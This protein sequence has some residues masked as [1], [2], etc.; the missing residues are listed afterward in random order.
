MQNKREGEK[1]VKKWIFLLLA[2]CVLLSGCAAVMEPTT[3]AKVA[4]PPYSPEC[5]GFFAFCRKSPLHHILPMGAHHPLL[6]VVCQRCG[7]FFV[8]NAK[9]FIPL[10]G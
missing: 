10:K 5:G 9:R 2:L 6:L 4:K 1:A 8:Q 3:P 7:M